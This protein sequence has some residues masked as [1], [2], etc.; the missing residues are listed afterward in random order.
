MLTDGSRLGTTSTLN[1]DSQ[2]DKANLWPQNGRWLTG[3]GHGS[4]QPG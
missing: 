1:S 3:A 4:G 2:F